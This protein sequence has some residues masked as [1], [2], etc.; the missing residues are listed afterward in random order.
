[1]PIHIRL[2]FAL[3]FPPQ[4]IPNFTMKERHPLPTNIRK[5]NSIYATVL[6]KSTSPLC[7]SIAAFTCTL[8]NLNN[9]SSQVWK[10]PPTP[11]DLQNSGSLPHSILL[12]PIL[13]IPESATSS[14]NEKIHQ[15]L[16]DLYLK[17]LSHSG[18][19]GATFSWQHAW[20]SPWNQFIAQFILKHWRNA[21]H[22]GVF[23]IFYIDPNEAAN[24]NV[25]LGILHRWFMGRAEGLRLGRFSPVQQ[26][27]KKKSESKSKWRSQVR[28]LFCI[29]LLA[30]NTYHSPHSLSFK[31]T[32]KRHF[33]PLTH[34]P[35]PRSCL[36]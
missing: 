10:L 18:F 35:K 3:L 11:Q 2:G 4:V 28:H 32:G 22:S 34:P 20:D 23:Q 6:P 7:R 36:T 14:Q 26:N 16:R 15:A 24:P 12:H 9:K 1:M 21:N 8:L 5:V 17:D 31:N 29:S 19:P 30:C 33:P 25:H 13:P 27:N